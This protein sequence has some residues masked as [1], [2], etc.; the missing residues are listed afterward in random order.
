MCLLNW[1]KIP[2][3]HRG[4]RLAAAVI[5]LGRSTRSLDVTRVC[6][7]KQIASALDAMTVAHCESQRRVK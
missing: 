6:E 4:Q 5:V 3:E 2:A 7:W 1:V